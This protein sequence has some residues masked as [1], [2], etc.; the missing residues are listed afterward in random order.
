MTAK[1]ICREAAA[2][3]YCPLVLAVCALA[4]G[5]VVDRC[6]PLAAGYW[7][8]LAA[9]GLAIWAVF[10]RLR[11]DHVASWM[12]LAA[13]LATGG[14]WHH[15]SWRLYPANDISRMVQEESRP[16]CIEAIALQSPRWIPAPPQTPLRTIPLGERSELLVQ[17]TSVRDGRTM[18]SASGL[19]EL[20]IGGLL[21]G[22]R[23]GD[24]LR[25]MAQA[26]RPAAPL[27]PGEFDFAATERARRVGCR[28]FAE[29]SHSVEPLSCGS[30]LLP[31]R[32]LANV[33]SGGTAILRRFI[34]YDRAM[35]AA[36]I[37]LGAREQLDPDRNEGYLVTGT[38]H[39]LSIS[40]LHVGILAALLFFVLRSGLA[41]R[42]FSLLATIGLTAGYALLTDLQPP[43]VRATILVI[44]ACIALWSGR[45]SIGFNVLAAAAI[46]VLALYPASLF[47]A[48]PQ[49]SFLA[50][51]TL[52]AF[53]NQLIAQPIL[54]PLD[55]LIAAT[56]PWHVRL[57][58]RIGGAM[59]RVWL[60]GALIWLVSAPLVWK[61][62]HL[63]SP[64]ALLLNFLMWIPISLAMY[65]GLGTLV[66][67]SFAPLAGQI[68]GQTCDCSLHVLERLIAVG[69]D[70]PASHA[71]VPSPPGWWI[72]LFY[73][74]IGIA[75]AFPAIRPR[76]HWIVALGPAWI[77]GS[78]ILSGLANDLMPWHK[79]RPLMCHFVA[80]GHGV[81]VLVELPDGR[82]L[83]YDAGRLGSPQSGVRPVSS[84]L[85]SRGI[86][87]LDA[88]V[89]SHADADHFNAIPGLL[90]RF[91][92]GVIYV[93]PVMFEDL[94]PAV[95]ELRE[96]IRRKGV[97]I[98]D[99]YAGRTLD[100]GTDTP[101]DV[102]HPPR[103]GVY[104]SDN[105]NSIVLLIEHAG[106]HVLLTGD[107]E[108]PG[109]EDVLAEDPIDC[110]VVLA[111]H[112]GSPRS[113]PGQFADWCTPDF[114]VISGR[115]GIDDATAIESVKHSF[116]LRGAEVF[117]TAE[118]GCVSFE[119]SSR[120]LSVASLRPHVRALPA[121]LTSA[122]LFQAE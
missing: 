110:D 94:P 3:T 26:S 49:L 95:Q 32:W 89:I 120:G 5:I 66:F 76:R 69:R 112:H 23:A 109:L 103:K 51:A 67:G 1:G 63:I 70:W 38:I 61:Q 9:T 48:G 99:L 72:G 91:S 55:R 74:A 34:E 92:I 47:Q 28:L 30:L 57:S 101:I 37:L 106:R 86:R 43:V 118:D 80:V 56:R 18:R 77:A 58:R 115:R 60:A 50:V 39:I 35:L 52:I 29:F 19:A 27:N 25:I 15:S 102:L 6:W 24:R 53:R 111:P 85:W 122:G 17:L 46:V 79:S 114:V 97:A 21:E 84:V 121:T 104:G 78:I 62:Y 71:W 113:S 11:H 105:A 36:A 2:P 73:L 31:R 108:S 20:N 16:F 119:I 83:L 8:L 54:D 68:C 13:V 41:A 10:W 42:W 88:L 93:A 64:V 96:A 81:S 87:H 116:R 45:S 4:A 100:A 44:S 98:R 75:V 90:E 65:S 107:L 14:A 59:W 33:R 7:W 82:N 117:H 40:G 22:I 12:L